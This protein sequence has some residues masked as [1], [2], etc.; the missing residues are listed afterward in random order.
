MVGEAV[1][2]APSAVEVVITVVSRFE[3]EVVPGSGARA[4]SLAAQHCLSGI[5]AVVVGAAI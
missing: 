2:S 4:V 1:R 5:F 3:K